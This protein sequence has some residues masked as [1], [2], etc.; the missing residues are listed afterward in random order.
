MTGDQVAASVAAEQAGLAAGADEF[1][2]RLWQLF[3]SGYAC[4]RDGS[5][6]P[7]WRL[8]AARAFPAEL[9]GVFPSLVGVADKSSVWY[10]QRLSPVGWVSELHPEGIDGVTEEELERVRIKRLEVVI[11]Y[12]RCMRVPVYLLSADFGTLDRH[13]ADLAGSHV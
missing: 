9:H 10:C 7:G 11:H 4:G 3:L 8:E 5:R 12:R 2:R 1:V 6:D 13:F